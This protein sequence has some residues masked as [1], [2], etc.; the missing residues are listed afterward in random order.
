[1][2]LDALYRLAICLRGVT[3]LVDRAASDSVKQADVFIGVE[4][5][6]ISQYVFYARTY[7]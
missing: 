4:A 3:W 5:L 1:M 6:V 2:H 7:T